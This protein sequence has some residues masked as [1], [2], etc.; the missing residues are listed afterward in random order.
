MNRFEAIKTTMSD[1]KPRTSREI[2]KAI[3]DDYPHAIAKLMKRYAKYDLCFC[4]GYDKYKARLW[5]WKD[6]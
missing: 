1:G 2:A 6:D 3:G 5:R 4:V